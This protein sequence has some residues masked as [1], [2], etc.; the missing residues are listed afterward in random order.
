M[1]FD[2]DLRSR[3]EEITER[4]AR[5]ASRAGRDPSGVTLVAVTKTLPEDA[6]RAAFSLGIRDIGEN[7]V[8][9]LIAKK[10][11]LGDLPLRW[12]LI[13]HLQT[14]KVRQ[15]IREVTLIHSVDTLHL[16]ER[17]AE[18]AP[19]VADPVEILLQV[20]TSGEVTKFGASPTEARPLAEGIARFPSLRL[21][22]LM[23]LGPLTDDEEAVRAS[24]RLL[25]RLREE[26]RELLPPDAVLSMGMSGDYEIAIEEGATIVRIGTALFG[27]RA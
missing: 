22:G 23:T 21:R 15:I 26:L 4:I 10:E 25:R 8:Q 9:E 19:D 3:H 17:I 24:F 2:M 7:R 18:A 1:A 11:A 20:N 27:A 16:V 12:H 14:N 5:A 6:V 13:G